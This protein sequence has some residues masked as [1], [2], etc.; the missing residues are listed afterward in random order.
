MTPVAVKGQPCTD[1]QIGTTAAATGYWCGRERVH[2][3]TRI[4][5]DGVPQDVEWSLISVIPD[6]PNAD[7]YWR[8][9]RADL[10]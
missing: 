6:A 1:A 4:V 7:L 10:R 8:I 2:I 3:E 5:L 9:N